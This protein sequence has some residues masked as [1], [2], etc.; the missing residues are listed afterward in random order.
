MYISE[1]IIP[2]ASCLLFEQWP[3]LFSNKEI[4][5]ISKFES[6]KGYIFSPPFVLF[7][8]FCAYE[9]SWTVGGFSSGRILMLVRTPITF[10]IVLKSKYGPVMKLFDE[11]KYIWKKE[12]FWST[13]WHWML[14]RLSSPLSL[15][16]R[17]NFQSIFCAF[18]LYRTFLFD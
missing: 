8:C 2:F 18:Y 15:E 10:C 4:V 13:F 14:L 5:L 7:A 17:S 6:A 9:G 11:K 12:R 1:S 3:G 16:L